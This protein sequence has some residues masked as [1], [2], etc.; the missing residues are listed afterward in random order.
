MAKPPSFKSKFESTVYAEALEAGR[1]LVYEP[2]KA[3]LKYVL[4]ARTYQPDFVLSPSGVVVETKGFLRYD[5]LRKMQAVKLCNPDLD[6]RIVFMKA[7]KLLRKG[8]SMT[9]GQWATKNGFPYAEGLIP[10]EWFK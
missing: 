2:T 4:P 5:D 6:I 9:Y 8:G 7:D 1:K 10:E 3:K